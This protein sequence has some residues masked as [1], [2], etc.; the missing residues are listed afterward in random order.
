MAPST[1]GV[2][3]A[4]STARYFARQLNHSWLS[5]VG[6]IGPKAWEELSSIEAE[7]LDPYEEAT[8]YK[9]YKKAMKAQRKE[10]MSRL[11]PKYHRSMK[12]DPYSSSS[13]R[14]AAKRQIEKIMKQYESH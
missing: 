14:Q 4:A 11:T 12:A 9:A 5:S 13:Y 1:S 2:Q 7:V 10:E 6:T 3:L 8:V